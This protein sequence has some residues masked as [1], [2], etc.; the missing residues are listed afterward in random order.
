[1]TK[2]APLLLVSLIA[3][4]PPRGTVGAVLSRDAE[5]RLHI[6][7]APEGLAADKAGLQS[8]D[9]II[10]IDGMDVRTLS[11]KELRQALRGEV[12]DKVK[13]TALRGEEV[14]RVTLKRTE[15]KRRL[16]RR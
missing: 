9:E 1:M 13:V 12:G 11:E 6:A 15:A 8:N 3:C 16:Q 10:L 7:E 14:V 4:A 2:I 5:G